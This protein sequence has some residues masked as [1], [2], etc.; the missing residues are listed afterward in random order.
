MFY[1]YNAIDENWG[2]INFHIHK[3]QLRRQR[4]GTILWRW[5]KKWS[6]FASVEE[7]SKN[8]TRSMATNG[9]TRDARRASWSRRISE[10]TRIIWL[11]CTRPGTGARFAV[12]LI[13][14]PTTS[15]DTSSITLS[16]RHWNK[17]WPR[18]SSQL[19]A[20]AK[21]SKPCRCY[22][23]RARALSLLNRVTIV[24]TCVMF[25]FHSFLWLWNF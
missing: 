23:S 1:T 5:K 8:T 22:A 20:F 19:I 14:V 17:S 6:T 18:S 21:D 9:F 4:R 16:S 25:R 24:T 3:I 7:D 15:W 13:R 2:K 12:M 10:N 11:L